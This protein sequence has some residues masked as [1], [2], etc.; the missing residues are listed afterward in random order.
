M[1]LRSARERDA[2]VASLKQQ[3]QQQQSYQDLERDRLNREL[4]ALRA[5]L[6][7][8]VSALVV[9]RNSFSV[10]QSCRGLLLFER[11]HML[12]FATFPQLN[13]NAEQKLEIDRLKRELEMARADLARANSSLQ[14][15]EMVGVLTY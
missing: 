1:L 2:E 14:S 4:E 12:D 11:C 15:R 6:Q 7:Q 3:A 9:H 10:F 13:I 5:Q 8:Q